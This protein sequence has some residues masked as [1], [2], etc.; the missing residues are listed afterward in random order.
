MLLPSSGI[1]TPFSVPVGQ[2]LSNLKKQLFLYI[3]IFEAIQN[4]VLMK[5]PDADTGVDLF[6]NGGAAMFKVVSFD[7]PTGI[8]LAITFASKVKSNYKIDWKAVQI[9]HKE[10]VIAKDIEQ[11]KDKLWCNTPGA[12]YNNVEVILQNLL[13]TK[14]FIKTVNIEPL[15]YR[16]YDPAVINEKHGCNAHPCMNNGKCVLKPE[17]TLGYVCICSSGYSGDNCQC[18][19]SANTSTSSFL[20]SGCIVVLFL[21]IIIGC[22]VYLH[23]FKERSHDSTEKTTKIRKPHSKTSSKGP[24]H[25]SPDSS[26]DDIEI[27][28][29]NEDC[30]SAYGT[31][32][33]DQKDPEATE[34]NVRFQVE[35]I[36]YDIK[37]LDALRNQ[38]PKSKGRWLKESN[39]D[40]KTSRLLP[41]DGIDPSAND[42]C[43]CPDQEVSKEVIQ[44]VSESCGVENDPADFQCVCQCK[45]FVDSMPSSD[46]DSM[47]NRKLPPRSQGDS[48]K[49]WFSKGD[50][51]ENSTDCNLAAK[52]WETPSPMA[53]EDLLDKKHYYLVSI[54]K[55]KSTVNREKTGDSPSQSDFINECCSETSSHGVLQ[56]DAFNCDCD[57]SSQSTDSSCSCAEESTYCALN[58][59]S[60]Q[61]NCDTLVFIPK[62]PTD[63]NPPQ[64]HAAEDDCSETT[65]V[66]EQKLVFPRHS[67]SGAV[68]YRLCEP[69]TVPKD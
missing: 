63:F 8:V 28:T 3:F 49:T 55:F 45:D 6:E 62:K 14:K 68:I 51:F 33:D 64:V 4:R 35:P 17:S 58:N 61:D 48:T 31:R 32:K 2:M 67:K 56:C 36:R 23:F 46:S 7:T 15:T 65:C 54:D 66:K 11:C 38:D 59:I 27:P 9:R 22:L 42:R 5:K 10:R 43:E 24:K 21:L 69:E 20:T 47:P 39:H 12:P 19:S 16:G 1:L 44:S 34:K 25:K 57:T 41:G 29:K 37:N 13:D 30:N 40:F 60:L 50:D 52:G 26:Y 18:A 53:N